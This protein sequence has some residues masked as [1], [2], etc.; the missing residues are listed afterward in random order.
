MNDPNAPPRSASDLRHLAALRRRAV[1]RLRGGTAIDVPTAAADALGVLHAMAAS[2]ATAGQALALLHEL[3]VH[4]VELDLQAQELRDACADLQAALRQRAERYDHL[5]VGCLT[6]DADFVVRE[7]NHRAA[8]LL[9]AEPGRAVG[10]PLAGL[11]D[12]DSMQR[13]QAAAAG[14]GAGR[15][16]SAS[17]L[18]LRAPREAGRAVAA[19]IAADPTA[20]GYLL[21][22]TVGPDEDGPA[23]RG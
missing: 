21:A 19:E 2:P 17:R 7:L 13:L 1:T 3:Q 16:G 6:L 4:Q 15:P 8:A 11:V 14:I 12:G 10:L 9:G 23:A 22:M 18:L 20:R 5:P